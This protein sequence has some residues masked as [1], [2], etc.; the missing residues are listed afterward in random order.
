[1]KRVEVAII[2]AGSAGMRA[3][4]E[5]SKVTDSIVLIDLISEPLN[6]Y[7]KGFFQLVQ[8]ALPTPRLAVELCEQLPQ[9]VAQLASRFEA[10][11]K[12]VGAR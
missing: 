6:F 4:R 3:Y 9:R 12:Q 11:R 1:M 8:G 10:W 7:V 2:G 5:A